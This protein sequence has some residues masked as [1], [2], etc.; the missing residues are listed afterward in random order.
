MSVIYI[1]LTISLVVALGFLC[2]FFVAV[3]RG[4]FDDSYT[5][6]VRILF[7]DELVSEKPK[8]N[9]TTQ[10]NTESSKSSNQDT[11]PGPVLEINSQDATN[12]QLSLTKQT[13]S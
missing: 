5:P 2:A 7:D 10:L 9:D 3:R 1:L 11:E 6:S 13:E 4:Q 12:I 8:P